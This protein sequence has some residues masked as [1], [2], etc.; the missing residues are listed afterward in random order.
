MLEILGY[1]KAKEERLLK[2]IDGQVEHFADFSDGNYKRVK[3]TAVIIPPDKNAARHFSASNKVIVNTEN[4]D[5]P[6]LP[7]LKQYESLL[8][9]LSDFKDVYIELNLYCSDFD[10]KTRRK[11]T[12]SVNQGILNSYVHGSRIFTDEITGVSYYTYMGHLV[13]IHDPKSVSQRH[14]LIKKMGFKGIFIR[15]VKMAADGNWDSLYGMKK[16]Q[17]K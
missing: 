12:L 7:D 10:F 16:A 1:L 2:H 9:S 5:M 6:S 3:N 8:S 4:P 15:D 14:N 11:T 17:N 13:W